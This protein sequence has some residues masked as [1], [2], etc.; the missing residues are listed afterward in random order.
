MEGSRPNSDHFVKAWNIRQKFLTL[1]QDAAA[2]KG[3]TLSILRA[4]ENR[5]LGSFFLKYWSFFPHICCNVE[6][7][8]WLEF[9]FLI[10][11]FLGERKSS[12]FKRP[13]W[14]C[15]KGNF[16]L[17]TP[18]LER[19]FRNYCDN[20]ICSLFSLSST[21]NKK[22]NDPETFLVEQLEKI[23]SSR[24]SSTTILG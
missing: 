6:A 12:A 17:F 15:C 14:R 7:C 1:V 18:E 2:F 5:L 20:L 3:Q 24:G 22:G 23:H 19:E 10:L 13:L 11:T 16:A 8:T 9:R 4:E 21:G